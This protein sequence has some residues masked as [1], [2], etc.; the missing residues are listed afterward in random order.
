MSVAASSREFGLVTNDT[1]TQLS[2]SG[3]RMFST[4]ISTAGRASD[5]RQRP[6][7]KL[8]SQVSES[9]ATEKHRP[10]HGVTH[11]PQP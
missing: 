5:M 10:S 8:D 9:R 11:H 3:E 4:K 7:D 6:Q 2:F 1:H